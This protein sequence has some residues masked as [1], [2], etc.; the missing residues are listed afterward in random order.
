MRRTATA[1]GAVLVAATLPTAADE[2]KGEITTTGRSTAFEQAD[3]NKDGVIDHA[4]FHDRQADVFFLLDVDKDGK[5][6]VTELG[7]V[8]TDR[9][10]VADQ[11]K[12][13]ALSLREFTTARFKDFDDADVDG[14]EVLTA[15][16]ID[17]AAKGTP[18]KK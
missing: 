12:D 8:D 4:E 2:P 11:D 9:F 7:E 16:E 13:G 10:V 3:K 5:L 1:L 6:T 14:D 15:T 18:Q 17:A